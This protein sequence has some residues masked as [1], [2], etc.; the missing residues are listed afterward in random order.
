MLPD[1]RMVGTPKAREP[2]EHASA[3]IVTVMFEE[4]ERVTNGGTEV[5]TYQVRHQRVWLAPHR[6]P[7]AEVAMQPTG[8]ALLWRKVTR[9]ALPLGTPVERVTRRPV[10]AHST[11]AQVLLGKAPG[12]SHHLHR[13][14]LAVGPQGRLIAP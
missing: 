14:A 3:E 12:L 4:S 6:I 11:T 7:G 9:V 13:V 10:R 1:T 8:P 2:Q 5:V